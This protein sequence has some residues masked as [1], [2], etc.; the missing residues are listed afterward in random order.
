LLAA[1][2][3]MCFFAEISYF[4]QTSEPE[5]LRLKFFL[6]AGALCS[7]QGLLGASPSRPPSSCVW[8]N[9][10]RVEMSW[11]D[12]SLTKACSGGGEVE[13]GGH[14]VFVHP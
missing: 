14:V 10:A 6:L 7:L 4:S 13:W 1:Q 12:E 2:V 3:E 5:C 9:R 11:F 8:W